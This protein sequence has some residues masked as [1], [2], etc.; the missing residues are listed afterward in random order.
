MSYIP[1][2][3]QDTIDALQLE[4]EENRIKANEASDA[5]AK[6]KKA[7]EGYRTGFWVV[8]ILLLAVSAYFG[9]SLMGNSTSLNHSQVATMQTEIDSLRNALMSSQE[10]EA[11]LGAD[12]N[13]EEGLWY[14]V[15]IGAYEELDLS[16]YEE[17][18]LNFRMR[19]E[20]G[21]MKYSLG[22]FR[23]ADRAES[24]LAAVRSIG[25]D[26]AWLLALNNG[27]RISIE[28]SKSL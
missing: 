3:A 12:L 16:M 10:N 11:M 6:E 17:G 4:V 14:F 24:F 13:F 25:I 7:S 8:L 26:D 9:Y 19:E 5:A 18:V 2:E 22:A 23:Q 21:L 27:Q 20:E 1:K 15:Q 28:E